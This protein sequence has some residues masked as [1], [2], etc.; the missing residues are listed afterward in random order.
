MAEVHVDLD[1][2]TDGTVHIGSI[3]TTN[4]NPFFQYHPDFL[5][6]G[7]N[8]PPFSLEFDRQPQSPLDK[9]GRLRSMFL[10]SAPDG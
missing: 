1:Y 3:A 10:D 5:E 2:G 7:V 9:Y 6:R 4:G 8:P